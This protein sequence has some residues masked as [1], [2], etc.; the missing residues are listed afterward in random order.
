M[1]PAPQPRDDWF[2]KYVVAE[3]SEVDRVG[4]GLRQLTTY[5]YVGGAAWHYV[6]NPLVPAERRTWSEWR[7]YEKV[8][9]RT[10]D[11][12]A[13]PGR[14]RSEVRSQY[15]RGMDGDKLAAGGTKPVSVVDSA[16]V[17][18]ADED[19]FAGF[20]REEITAND[21]GGPVVTGAIHDPW[22]RGPTAS[23]GSLRAFQ[24]ERVR[25]ATRSALSAGGFRRTRVDTSFDNE[26]NPTQ[27]NDL[28]DVAVAADDRCTRTTYARNQAAWL[29]TLASRVETVGVACT[30]TP[31]FPADAISDVRTYY[32]G[33]ALGAAP[34]AGDPTMTEEVVA[35][36]GGTPTYARTS[37]STYDAAGRVLD[38]FDALDRKTATRYVD[39]GGLTTG[40]TVTNPLGHTVTTT[41][42]P[43]WGLA[44]AVV[45]A[46]GRRTDLTYDGLGRLTGVWRPG[47]SKAAG[48]GPTTRYAYGVRTTGANWV[49]TEQLM[50]G[51][52]YAASH[53]L[54]DGFLRERQT[55][56][57]SSQGGRVLTDTLYDSR[58]LTSVTR[59]PYYN[60]A[61]A[62][63]TLF[64][65]DDNQVP[66]QTVVRF[67]GAERPVTSAYLKLNV[68]QWRTTTA[69]G[70]DH[71]DVT[72]PR[73]GTA[74]T[75]WTD[76]RDQTTELW[77]YRGPAP[78]PGGAHDTTRYGY[79]KAGLL[80]S[81]TDAAG[82]TWRYD[83]DVR[84]RQVRADDPDKGVATMTYDAADELLTTTDARGSTIANAYDGLGRK[85]GTRRG[86]AGGELL[87][88][89]TYDQLPDGTQERGALIAS[90]RHVG[91]NAYVTAVTGF[92]AAGR[93]T[94][95]ATTIPGA[96]AGLA[97]TYTTRY[98]YRADG[99][100]A[101]T[102]L[103]ALGD[104]PAETLVFGY[105]SLGQPSTMQGGTSTYIA[106]TTYT[107][108]NERAQVE[109]GKTGARVWQTTSYEEGTRRLTRLL[110]EREQA[111]N[112][113]VDEVTYAYDQAGNVTRVADALP[114]SATDTNCFT[115]DHLQRTVEAWTAT[116]DCAA[117]PSGS[118]VGGPAPSWQS[119]TYD[120]TGSRTRQTRHG[121]GGAADTVSSSTYPAAGADR[122]HAVRSVQTT[123]PGAG[124]D[125]YAYD[126]AGNLTGRQGPAGAQTLT[127]DAE[128]LLAS[129]GSTGYV[130]DAGG[131]QLIRRDPGAATLFVGGGELRLDTATGARKAVRYYQGVG[132][133]TSAGMSYLLAD[134]H[135]TSQVA[136]NAATLAA[137]PRRFDLFGNPR[138]TPPAPWPGGERAFVDGTANPATGLTR[139]GAREYDPDLGAFISV[140]PVVDPTDPQQL[141]AYAYANNNPATMS[142][143]D[144]LR[145]FE[146]DYGWS[147]AGRYHR[148]RP[149][150]RP[151]RA[152]S[153]PRPR[154][155]DLVVP[156]PLTC[157][158]H[159]RPIPCGPVRPARSTARFNDFG[160]RCPTGYRNYCMSV[161]EQAAA[162]A[163]R[164]RRTALHDPGS[165]CP[166][167]DLAWCRAVSRGAA[168]GH[169]IEGVSPELVPLVRVPNLG[170]FNSGSVCFDMS[171]GAL[172]AAGA[173]GCVNWDSVGITTSMTGRVGLEGGVGTAWAVQLRLNSDG[174]TDV[175]KGLTVSA[176]ASPELF[177]GVGGGVKG[178]VEV[179]LVDLKP[180]HS[181][182]VEFGVGAKVS[183]GGAYFNS[184][185]NSGYLVRWCELDLC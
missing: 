177:L 32:D 10:G 178:G 132:L 59:Q 56:A 4:N 50:A 112:V 156:K 98:T 66:S 102:A 127:W 31:S 15:F 78:A 80:A 2:H 172:L 18:L 46:N 176:E 126:A 42:Q 30:A 26:G 147:D 37:R 179:N 139:L 28:G 148:P 96:E 17:A 74:T 159:P 160:A 109:L 144:G 131:A 83:Y 123:G 71:V 140:D 145:Y 62:G 157:A 90:T 183:L 45:D 67:D 161:S 120:L 153:Q 182:H 9:V 168:I 54:L 47:R 77:Q 138:G 103:P 171:A 180:G 43:A 89:W 61:A 169:A 130:H 20:L 137:T 64:L 40:G 19:P 170:A 25:T 81:V 6:D 51:G 146:G 75:T 36:S 122:P 100:P 128:G 116:G 3:V 27:V 22:K 155:L 167:W 142:D 29:L 63:T 44:Q 101:S 33:G 92:D 69:Y 135:G 21:A 5:E 134:H 87:A 55:Q 84:G 35:Y 24:V 165:K 97:G 70:G 119:F 173:N 143:P 1:P 58:G 93:P 13:E 76:A 154:W 181:V 52:N 105:D 107:A 136:I 162:Q 124:T 158:S 53:L 108:L 94:G 174:A 11:P 163:R 150:P 166:P 149:R 82:N 14:P 106:A 34:G 79:T 8:V 99:S 164:N 12:A 86:S 7:G 133:R 60:D 72:P 57:P 68:E 117:A 88:S 38:S 121:L 41:Y 152:P 73:G 141:N 104:L 129:A 39:S 95:E 65:P 110:T 91:G 49:R 23:Q 114:G 185:V 125:A 115:Y 175:G 151:A 111:G 16:G 184:G 113:R 85:V 48:D 118:T